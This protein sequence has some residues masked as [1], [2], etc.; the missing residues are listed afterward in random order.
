MMGLDSLLR[1]AFSDDGIGFSASARLLTMGLDSL[2]DSSSLM[3]GLDSL[4]QLTF[5]DDGI[6][7]SALAC[8]L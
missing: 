2:L 8:L 1:L 3:M 4:L 5:S 6:G 7:F